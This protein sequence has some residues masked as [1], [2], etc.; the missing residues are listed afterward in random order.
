MDIRRAVICQ[1][2]KLV[3]R[4]LQGTDSKSYM[5]SAVGQ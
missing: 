1:D 4:S 3:I 2:G 5:S